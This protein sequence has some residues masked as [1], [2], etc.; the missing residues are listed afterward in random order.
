MKIKGKVNILMISSSSSLGGGTK[1]M[2][3][4]GKNLSN[5]FKIFYAI[6]KNNNFENYLNFENHIEISERKIK[7]KDLLKLNNYIKQNSIDLIHAHGKG[8]G[9]LARILKIMTKKPL[10][11]TFHGIHIKCHKFHERFVYVLYEFLLGW[12]DSKKILV[13]ES[14]KNYA[15]KSKIY[16]GKKALVINNGVSNKPQKVTSEAH[17]KSNKIFEFS[18]T[19]VITI[20]RFVRQKNIKDILK[21]ASLLEGINFYIIG[22]GPLWKEINFLKSQE[23]L[24]NVFLMGEKKNV[25]KYLYAADVYLS[26]SLYEGLPISILEA[27]SVGL[28]VLASNV[29]GNCDTIENG[30]SGYFYDLNNINMAIN[31]LLKLDKNLELRKKLG[32]HAFMRQRKF[33]SKELMLAKHIELYNNQEI[34]E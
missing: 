32:S 31:Y 4:L 20:C 6:P 16:L 18:K 15:K 33:F 13:S 19:N 14:E 21:I 28:P 29:I 30:R 11:Y 27:M 8:A 24:N 5:Y 10:I 25:F 12:L 1:Q 17:R 34:W 3:S 23:N 22:G 7:P 26:T 2:F 9:A